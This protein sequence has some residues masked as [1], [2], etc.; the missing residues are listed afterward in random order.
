MKTTNR[1]F[2]AIAVSALLISMPSFSQE[3]DRPDYVSVTTMYWNK[4]YNASMA[5]W[6]AAEKEY[7]EKV[8]KK[9][10]HIMGSSY[11]THLLT[12]NSNEIMYIQ[13]YPTWEDIDKAA[14]RSAELEKEAWP[15]ADAR[16]TF[17]EKMNSAYASYHSDEIYAT[18][19]G[20][21]QPKGEM[22]KDMILYM[23]TN[24]MAYP[25]DGNNKEY[26]ELNKKYIENVINKNDLIIGY[27]PGVH[28][29][30]HDKRDFIEFFMIDSLGDLDKMF[31]KNSELSKAAFTEEESKAFGKYFRSHG[32]AVYTAIK[33]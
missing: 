14:A 31:E 19:P 32:D 7:M 16:K 25:E 9:N 6:K 15:D 20:A 24:K 28:G 3:D 21:K 23:R 8:T 22:S 5:E 18:L 26:D 27:W 30:G 1:F 12:P 4:D 17:L 11:H 2:T 29:W 13:V 10:E 33:L